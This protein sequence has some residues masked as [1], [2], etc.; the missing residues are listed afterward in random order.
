MAKEFS[1]F[2]GPQ[3]WL[4][5]ALGIIIILIGTGIT[6]IVTRDYIL[7]K[8]DRQAFEK[9]TIFINDLYTLSTERAGKP[10]HYDNAEFC[11]RRAPDEFAGIQLYCRKTVAAYFKLDEAAARELAN[12]IATYS[13]EQLGAVY[14]NTSNDPGTIIKYTLSNQKIARLGDVE[15]AAIIEYPARRVF[16]AEIPTREFI[17]EDVLLS[18]LS[19]AKSVQEPLF[20][21][22]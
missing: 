7:T 3:K 22:R 12:S 21:M 2:K 4:Y 20:P 13:E 11:Y 10:L 18:Q 9:T 14:S 8:Q 16:L 15:C 1:L 5:F 17:D 19:C 6:T